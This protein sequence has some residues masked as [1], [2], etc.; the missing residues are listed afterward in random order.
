MYYLDFLCLK[1]GLYFHL[2]DTC[3]YIDLEYIQARTKAQLM[4]PCPQHS[5]CQMAGYK[6]CFPLQ[7]LAYFGL[8]S[9]NAPLT[10]SGTQQLTTIE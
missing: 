2:R 5:A 9:S 6:K 8:C 1:V 10:V 3:I 4:S 7:R